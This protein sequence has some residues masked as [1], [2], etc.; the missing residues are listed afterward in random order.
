MH[1]PKTREDWENAIDAVLPVAG[2]LAAM[3]TLLLILIAA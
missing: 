2:A 3:T 1:T